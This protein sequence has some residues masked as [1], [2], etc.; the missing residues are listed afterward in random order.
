[1]Q[2]VT[3]NSAANKEKIDVFARKIMEAHGAPVGPYYTRPRKMSISSSG[4]QRDGPAAEHGAVSRPPPAREATCT[5]SA[6]SVRRA[7]C[8]GSGEEDHSARTTARNGFD[9]S[10]IIAQSP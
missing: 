3:M 8:T 2:P 5:S 4:A 9:E 6:P 10:S 1:M 7:W